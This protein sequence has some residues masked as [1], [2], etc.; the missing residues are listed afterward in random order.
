M[1]G[2]QDQRLSDIGQQVSNNQRISLE[3]AAYLYDHAG[4]GYLSR[5][6]CIAKERHSGRKVF[7]NRNFHIEPTNVCVNHCRFCSYSRE[8]GQPGAWEMSMDEIIQKV[9][10]FKHLDVTEIHIVGGVHPQRDLAYYEELLVQIKK[11]NP[12]VRIKAFTA[13]ELDFMFRKSNVSV[14][15]GLSR[16][17]AAGLDSIPGGGAEIFDEAIRSRICPDK[18]GSSTWLAIHESAHQLGIPTSCTLLYGHLEKFE[19]RIDHM[20]RLRQLQ[21]RT[22]GFQVFIPLKFRKENNELGILGEVSIIEDLRN[23]AISRIF[24]DNI[25][26]L[27]AYWPMIGKDIA[28]LSL[29]FGVDDLDGTIEDTTRIYSMAGAEEQNPVMTTEG[30]VT[31]I[32]NSGFEPVE[33]DTLYNTLKIY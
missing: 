8:I 25:P 18:T 12:K 19:H 16:L 17:H 32:R 33:R 29:S 2:I 6:A 13:V 27:K 15:E 26:H 3:D 10:D 11:A 21:D 31:L 30:L 20:H 7:F 22:G 9:N 28:A 24:L 1:T 5:L 14:I 4:L 23:F